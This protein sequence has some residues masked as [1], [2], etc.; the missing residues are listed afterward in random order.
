MSTTSKRIEAEAL[1]LTPEERA[2]LAD[3]LW[4]S[5]ESKEA[6]ADAWAKEIEQR[7]RELRS[8]A[9]K[10]VSHE[11]AVAELRSRYGE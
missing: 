4:L 7:V 10:P 1:T 8:G 9:V 11:D 2:D 6:V 3:K 5:V